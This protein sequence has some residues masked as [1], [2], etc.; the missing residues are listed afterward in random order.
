MNF[1]IKRLKEHYA[2]LIKR[3]YDVAA[4][5]LQGSQNYNL[6]EYSEEYQSDIDSK[7]IIIPN[8]EDF[9]KNKS[10]ISETIILDNN[11]HIDVKDI[12]I[13]FNMFKKE[14]LSY[15]ELLYTKYKIIND[16]YEAL[17]SPLFRTR[18]K[19][20]KANEK[21]FIKCICG[22]SKE[23]RKAL[24]HPYPGIIEKINKYGY[25]GKQLSHCVRLNIFL[26]DYL[27]QKKSI[28]ECFWIDN[29][30]IRKI[31]IDLKKQIDSETGEVLS[32]EKAIE[33][34]KF[35]DEQNES[36]KNAVVSILEENTNDFR[37]LDEIQY[38]VLRKKIL[39][40]KENEIESSCV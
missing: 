21:Q 7:A 26:K 4:L 5:F 36:I 31:L 29:A 39:D 18:D 10:P 32:K 1:I 23:K 15:I 9:I 28:E 19:I 25:D 13:M 20:V 2:E 22:M 40:W 3:G 16:R 27:Y 8:V 34:C 6:D 38:N 30:G 14:N 37:I 12:R 17:L 11:E 35:Y 24:C 33:L